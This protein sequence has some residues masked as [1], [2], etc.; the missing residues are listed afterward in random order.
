MPRTG[1]KKR[2][3]IIRPM[4]LLQ[5][6]AKCVQLSARFSHSP[7]GWIGLFG[8]FKPFEIEG[9]PL[10]VL[11]VEGPPIRSRTTRLWRVSRVEA[12]L[13][14]LASRATPAMQQAL[15]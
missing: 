5:G 12:L 6:A 4:L 7:S 1:L 8:P 13:P 3:H 9:K 11:T 14:F 10:H 2:D 15:A